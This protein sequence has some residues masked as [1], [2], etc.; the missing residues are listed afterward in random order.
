MTGKLIRTQ[1]DNINTC[2]A[3]KDVDNLKK[4]F[5]SICNDQMER[6]EL[7]S[8]VKE[9]VY[10]QDENGFWPVIIDKT[11]P[12]DCRVFYI[13]YPTYYATCI[14]IRAYLMNYGTEIIKLRESLIKGLQASTGRN[15]VGSGYESTEILLEVLKVFMKAGVIELFML[16]PDICN[17][18]KEIFERHFQLFREGINNGKTFSDWDRDFKEE[19]QAMIELYDNTKLKV[20]V[21]GTLM[22]G[23]GNSHY[24]EKCKGLGNAMISG[25][26]LYDTGYGFPGIKHGKSEK[27]KGEVYEIETIDQLQ[28]L[29]C[30]EGNG[31]LYSREF[32]VAHGE[33]G[34][35][36]LVMAYVYNGSVDE[37][38]DI[39]EDD[40]PWG[41]TE[42]EYVWYACYGSNLSYH[43]FMKYINK[44]DDK[45]PPKK[46]MPITIKHDMYY[47]LQSSLWSDMAVAFI[48]PKYD[49][50]A[51]T[52]GRMYLVTK[53][54]YNCV[55]MKEGPNYR[56]EL[57]LGYFNNIKIV[58][59]T[60]SE[61]HPKKEPSQEYLDVIKKGLLE[62]Y[63]SFSENDAKE[64]LYNR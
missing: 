2:E 45:T 44:C 14:L 12:A 11:M 49:E 13:Y 48:N 15:L 60:N 19:F 62:T 35:N 40:Q 37:M 23:K 5:D 53:K 26:R 33:D 6:L 7:K 17:T 24:L 64:Y 8:I 32:V 52:L 47:A 1:V 28:R 27:V 56:K 31:S 46:W 22:K 20:F 10:Q 25:F 38:N 34:K 30:L 16:E 9:L 58:T 3:Q 51:N 41:S 57:C 59:F 50:C 55:K 36:E 4:I 29:D 18:F 63:P 39:N 21:Y 61:V 43:R 42:E 54:Q